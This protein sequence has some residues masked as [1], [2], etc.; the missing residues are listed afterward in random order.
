MLL[1]VDEKATYL[2]EKAKLESLLVRAEMLS[3]EHENLKNVFN[4]IHTSMYESSS[5]LADIKEQSTRKEEEI[6]QASRLSEALS[7]RYQTAMQRY[8]RIKQELESAE[9]RWED[10]VKHI[11]RLREANIKLEAGI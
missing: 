1:A 10:S 11:E 6:N 8:K 7:E 3:G 4:V 9:A 2:E 5:S